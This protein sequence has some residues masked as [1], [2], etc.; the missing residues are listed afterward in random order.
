[1]E[2]KFFENT[3]RDLREREIKQ[4]ISLIGPHRD[5]ICFLVN[6]I[7]IR[8]FGS[9]GQQ[10]TAALS[11]KLSEIAL[12]KKLRNDTPVLLLDDVMS[13]LD[14]TRQLQL[15]NYVSSVQTFLTCTGL[16]DLKN[17]HFPI[18]RLFLVSEGKVVCKNIREEL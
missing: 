4:K 5:D 1:M 12:I 8:K 3:L 13:E 10:R 2:E 6:G 15:L 9:Q 7:D 18:D 11:L 17:C 14:S 16:D